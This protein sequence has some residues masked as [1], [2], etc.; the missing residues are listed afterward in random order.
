MTGGRPSASHGGS[1][2]TADRT[3]LLAALLAGAAIRILPA[4]STVFAGR[5]VRFL[6]ADPLYH[7]RRIQ[8]A[9]HHFPSILNVDPY[10][11]FP[12]GARIIWPAGFDLLLAAA[13]RI[14]LHPASPAG[15]ERLCA[16]AVPLL[17]LAAI[18]AVYALG[19]AAL[20]APGAGMAALTFALLPYPVIYSLL[21]YVDHH[22]MEPFFLALAAALLLSSWTREGPMAALFG[23]LAGAIASLSFWFVTDGAV[24]VALICALATWEAVRG[25]FRG[26]RPAGL[27]SVG[28]AALTLLALTATTPGGLTG[29][30][31]YLALSPFQAHLAVAGAGLALAL[32]VAAWR[33]IG[34][35]KRAIGV[36]GGAAL[37]AVALAHGGTALLDPFRGAGVFVGRTE[38]L[39]LTVRESR[40]LWEQPWRKIF[41]GLSP[42]GVM[43]PA[44]LLVAAIRDRHRPSGTAALLGAA[45]LALGVVQIR[46]LVIGGVGMAYAAGWL[47]ARA[48]EAASDRQR[49]GLLR[50]VALA[51]LIAGI[52]PTTL[53]VFLSSASIRDLASPREDLALADALRARRQ[54]EGGLDQARPRLDWGVVARWDVGHLLIYRGEAP[55]VACPFGLGPTHAEGVR[56]VVNLAL[57]DSD[58]AASD[59]CRS[60]KVRYVATSDPFTRIVDDALTAGV[61]PSRYVLAYSEAKGQ[62]EYTVNFLRT[63]AFRLHAL[64]GA[65]LALPGLQIPAMPSFRLIWESAETIPIVPLAGLPAGPRP[66]SNKLFEVVKG[67]RVEGTCVPGQAVGLRIAVRTN[68]GRTLDWRN[69]MPCTA[70]GRYAIRTPYASPAVKLAQEGREKTLA[71]TEAQVL[72]GEAI[73]VN[74]R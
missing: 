48:W 2:R 58:A 55:V 41:L 1:G 73:T 36:L 63:A 37:A 19:K 3:I 23:G 39:W 38:G 40:P 20:A 69:R 33:E 22:V 60:L 53:L 5:E 14:L 65:F 72:G 25:R 29:G 52:V 21:G 44:V 28:A 42:L 10:V 67:A 26:A 24:M 43:L 68:Q 34:P 57:S 45:V 12:E 32:I 54:I 62:I 50:G 9:V 61:P 47:A 71:V 8:Y 46:F 6:S 18:L 17:G 66:S 4:W 35:G 31:T 59:L 11:N 74:L 56:R 30:M 13:S 27:S 15:V 16:L 64:D 51:V 7:L 49:P 70:L